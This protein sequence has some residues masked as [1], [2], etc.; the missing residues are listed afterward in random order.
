MI[1][2]HGLGRLNPTARLVFFVVVSLAATIVHSW[3]G[4]IFFLLLGIVL[5]AAGRK[6]PKS[7]IITL[8]NVFILTVAGNALFAKEGKILFSFFA[9]RL[10]PESLEKGLLLGCRIV[11]M[12]LSAVAF[13][14]ATPMYEFLPAVRGLRIRNWRIPLVAELYLMVLLRYVEVT[15]Y[16]IKQTMKAMLI[17]GV[18][19]EGSPIKK[20]MAFRQLMIPMFYRIINHISG[21][22]LAID[23]RGSVR[24]VS[25]KGKIEKQDPAVSMEQVSVT[26]D[27]SDIEGEK[28]LALRGINL[29][30]RSGET[31]AL[32]GETGSGRS[33]ASLL[34]CGLIPMSI[35]RMAGEVKIFGYDT[36]RADP[37]L[38]SNLSRIV[39]PSAIQGLVG[40]TVEDELLL[41]LRP[42][43]IPKEEYGRVMIEALE[44]VGLD[45]VFLNR[46]TL[47]L[48]GGEMQR[49]AL[50]SAII[51]QPPILVL[52][53]VS[54][55]LDPRAR[56]EVATTLLALR[57]TIETIILTDPSITVLPINKY[58]FLEGGRV[59]Q[60]VSKAGSELLE[61]AHVRIP[62]LQ[63]LGDVLGE[64]FGS[65]EEAVEMLKGGKSEICFRKEAG[66]SPKNR[67]VLEAKDITFS[68]EASLEPAIRGLSTEFRGGE[69]TA[70]LGA[71]GSGKTTL[72]LILAQ[73][74]KPEIGQILINGEQVNSK[75]R[76][77]IGYVFQEPMSQMLTLTVLDELAFGPH[78]LGWRKE[79]I[80]ESV[81]DV[82]QIFSLPL[83]E[84]LMDLSPAQSRQLAIG[85]ILTMKPKVLILDEPTNSLDE[86]EA[87]RL[88]RI[89]ED[90]RANGM[91][92]ILITHDVELAV[93]YA[94]R[95][96]VMKEGSILIDG[97]TRQ[98]MS[99]PEILIRSE[100]TV[101]DITDLSLRLWPQELPALTVEEMV[102]MLSI[103]NHVFSPSNSR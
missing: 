55:Q 64:S 95:I 30:I 96:M 85:S 41:S 79:E 62:Q 103:H 14:V 17:R 10:S 51:A 94:D 99:K 88:M 59:N 22:A 19:F 89:L 70:I 27:L 33:T 29:T 39:F 31:C 16:E 73:A 93:Q 74:Y 48:S 87:V 78:Q 42:T 76:G 90:L 40:L 52:D 72:G 21:Q 53:D 9:F 91:T 66:N 23:S 43:S 83:K 101:P 57:E 25:A 35:G 26:Y 1:R 56:R 44:R 36:K 84:N 15:W 38:L 13:A 46:L 80:K 92:I 8:V 34:C 47:S 20:I 37:S 7:S 61:R 32:M 11:A 60:I 5:L 77:E 97:S 102:Q 86:M 4:V 54:A 82:A 81:D 24:A 18:Q 28:L 71:N 100:V 3:P 2:K 49:V 65:M 12:I 75:M 50:A 6:C 67:V 68:Y 69:L 45:S 58:V 63:K 98:V